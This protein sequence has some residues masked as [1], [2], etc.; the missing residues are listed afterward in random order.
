MFQS[1]PF[2]LTEAIL[3]YLGDH[4]L[5]QTLR[6]ASFLRYPSE[7]RLYHTVSLSNRSKKGL[8]D[9]QAC[10][11]DTVIN[12]CRLA[13]Y[14]VVLAMGGRTPA[15]EDDPKV[16]S[17]IGQAMKNMINLKDLEISGDPYIINAQLDSVPFSLNRLYISQERVSEAH[18]P[19]FIPILRAHPN[20]EEVAF[21]RRTFPSD[22]LTT[23]KAED[24]API[25]EILC[26]HLRRFDGYDCGLRLF[27][28]RRTIERATTIGSGAELI[29]HEELADVWLTPVLTSAYRHLRVLEVWP[30]RQKN[31]CFLSTVAPYLTFLTHLL[32]VDSFSLI[33]PDDYLLLSL[34]RIPA[35]KS[36]TISDLDEPRRTVLADAQTIVDLVCSVCPDIAEIFV[37]GNDCAEF[38]QY[39]KGKGL[40]SN[41][42]SKEIACRPYSK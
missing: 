32:I 12:N 15:D 22:L 37:G 16:N 27:L 31:T 24:D 6:I 35:L 7:K 1:L 14:V 33:F 21:D 28:A 8:G 39:T 5:R 25:S 3:D 4:A 36:F 38:Y 17:V 42:V 11:L 18:F 20:L 10:F 29:Y 34:G 13:E 26:P 40:H 41:L 9:R 23:L 30:D 2:E 19:S